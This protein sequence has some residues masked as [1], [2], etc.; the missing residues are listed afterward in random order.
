M[1]ETI[2]CGVDEMEEILN[3]SLSFTHYDR[4]NDNVTTVSGLVSL[5]EYN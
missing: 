3:N 4:L 2:S 1:N 5:A